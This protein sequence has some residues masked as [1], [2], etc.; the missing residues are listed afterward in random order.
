MDELA[1]GYEPQLGMMPAQQRFYAG[2]L[3]RC[4]TH[5]RL[6]VEQKLIAL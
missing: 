6:V 5:F 2:D 3:A 4:N 1:R